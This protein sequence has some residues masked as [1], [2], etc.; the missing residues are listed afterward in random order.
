[1]L[2]C[3]A[4]GALFVDHFAGELAG[5]YRELVEEHLAGCASCRALAMDYRAVIALA[6]RLPPPPPPPGLLGR[7]RR[8]ARARGL[9]RGGGAEV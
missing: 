4:V 7:L 3:R 2:S 9:H 8:K 6:R 5:E 1:M